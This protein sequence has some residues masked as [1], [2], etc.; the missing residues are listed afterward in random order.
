MR[1]LVLGAGGMAGH[2]VALYLRENG[3]AVDT[4]SAKNRF[5]GATHL[6]NVTEREKLEAFLRANSYDV[7]INCIGLLVRQSEEQRGLAVYLNSFLP[8]HLEAHYKDSKT[9]VI[10]LSTDCVFSG[11]HPP[12]RENS[13]YDGELFYDRTKAL[14]EVVNAKDLTFRM[15]IVGPEIREDGVGLFNWFWAQRGDISGY[16]R[17]MWNGITTIELAKGMKAAIEQDLTGLYHLTPDN[18]ISKCDLLEIFRD[19]FK[20]GDVTIWPSAD[21]I[22]DK[23]L[24][25]TRTDFEYRV[26]DYTNMVEEMKTWIMAHRDRYKHY[27]VED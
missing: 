18:S 23:T 15:S 16:T 4:L 27:R 10:Q 1:V 9:K 11:Q 8:H 19:V 22:S 7:V 13:P 21:L 26:P 24:L 3:F 6:I 20:R 5:D 12:Y 25:N 2:V 14:G 17:A